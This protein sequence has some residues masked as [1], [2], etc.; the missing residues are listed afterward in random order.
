MGR[1]EGVGLDSRGAAIATAKRYVRWQI[2]D[3]VP[4]PGGGE[5]NVCM[6][7]YTIVDG[8]ACMCSIYLL[9]CITYLALRGDVRSLLQEERTDRGMA[10]PGC[11]MEGRIPQL[12]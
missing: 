9:S 12:Q 4:S 1:E 8:M 10:I 2:A 5:G 11:M 7:V 6:Y 3:H